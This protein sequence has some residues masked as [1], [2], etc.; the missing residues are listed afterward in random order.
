MKMKTMRV[1]V[2]INALVVNALI[3]NGVLSCKQRNTAEVK[4]MKKSDSKLFEDYLKAEGEKKS[5]EETSKIY[6]KIRSEAEALS[7]LSRAE[8]V[9][10]LL[11]LTKRIY[12]DQNL[13]ENWNDIPESKRAELSKDL[14]DFAMLR[15]MV[16]LRKE[17][18]VEFATVVSDVYKATVG[19]KYIVQTVNGKKVTVLNPNH[20]KI[21]LERFDDTRLSISDISTDQAK[22]MFGALVFAAFGYWAIVTVSPNFSGGIDGALT[23]VVIVGGAAMIVYIGQAFKKMGLIMDDLSESSRS[24]RTIFD[25]D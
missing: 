14:V 23:A 12:L 13:A 8:T 10:R 19:H 22:F 20:D 15:T 3:F 4:E 24:R 2:M 25:Q 21:P 11:S 18:E 9:S 17:K 7:A 16:D 6:E 1:N 5:D